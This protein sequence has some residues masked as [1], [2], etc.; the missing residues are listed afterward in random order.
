MNSIFYFSPTRFPWAAVTGTLHIG[1]LS[2]NSPPPPGDFFKLPFIHNYPGN[3]QLIDL[4][5]DRKGRRIYA[6]SAKSSPDMLRSVVNSFL[7]LYNITGDKYQL[8]EVN[9]DEGLTIWLSRHLFWLPGFSK[10]GKWLVYLRFKK[11]FH[12][13]TRLV[14]YKEQQ[15]AKLD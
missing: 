10:L 8:V 15:T 1:K 14:I 2:P 9:I 6:F 4:G 3:G 5:T 11:V 12:Q 13:L 7:R